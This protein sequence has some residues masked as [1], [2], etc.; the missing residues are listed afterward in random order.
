MRIVV[1]GATGNVGTALLRRL[2]REPDIEVSGVAR[3]TPGPGAGPPYDGVRWHAADLGDPSCLTP[4]TG[5]L[6]GADAVVHLAWQI[7]P[8]HCRA[9]LRRTNLTGTRHLLSALREAGVPKL[10]YAS[11]VGA[12][13]PGPKD[14]RVTEEWPTTGVHG[15]GYSVDKAA[16]ETML[17]VFELEH[18]ELRVVRLRKALIFQRDAG[19]EITRYFLGRLGLI[20][21]SPSG[22]PFAVPRHERLRVQA[23]HADDVAEAYLQALRGD[24]TGAFNIA[25]EP[26]LDGPLVA[27][28]L[29]SLPVP[30]P[31]GLLRL[32]MRTAWWTHLIPPDPGWLDLAASVPLLDCSRAER[33]WGWRPRHDARYALRE[34]LAGIAA[35]AGTASPPLRPHR[36][37]VGAAGISAS[38]RGSG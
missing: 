22:R 30:V 27:K 9:R 28:E 23:V 24:Q 26:A 7:Q 32:G 12:Y 10:V 17:D 20:A 25:A 4:L 18:P 29:K 37:A 31:L 6:R 11:S 5:W 15:S 38:A 14:R 2:A 35:G 13:R 1:T 16:V 8:S 34:M 19:S 21:V 33:E 3:R 36:A